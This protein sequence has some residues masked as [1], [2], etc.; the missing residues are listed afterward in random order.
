[1]GI[2]NFV[3]RFFPNFDVMVKPIHNMIKQ[4]Q[5]LSWIEDVEKYFVGIKKTISSASVLEK[6]DFDQKSIIYT[7]SIEETIFVILL[8]KYDQNNEHSIAY[9]S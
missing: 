8:Q 2:I 7:N 4:D 3:R 9:M 6:P 1:M 5:F